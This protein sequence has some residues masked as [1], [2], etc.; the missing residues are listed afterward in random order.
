[1]S[2][3]ESWKHTNVF[4]ELQCSAQRNKHLLGVSYLGMIGIFT[5]LL[6]SSLFVKFPL[7]HLVVVYCT[8]QKC[9]PEKKNYIK[10]HGTWQAVMS[11]TIQI[12]YRERSFIVLKR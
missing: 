12:I 8:V 4:Q 2:A 3:W 9:V 1:M 5:R 10:T 11:K 7:E 6:Q